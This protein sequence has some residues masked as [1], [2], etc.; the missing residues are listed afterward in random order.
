MRPVAEGIAGG[1]PS[2]HDNENGN[3]RSF[4]ASLC[5]AGE[6]RVTVTGAYKKSVNL[7]FPPANT[8]I[9]FLD[10]VVTAPVLSE[11]TIKWSVRFLVD[12]ATVTQPLTSHVDRPA[13]KKNP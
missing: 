7:M 1:T 2:S 3:D 8:A 6:Q 13:T 9:R 11:K 12:K 10:D 4:L 5:D